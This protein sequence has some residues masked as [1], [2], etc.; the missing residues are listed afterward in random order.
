M[1]L[2][3]GVLILKPAPQYSFQIKKYIAIA[4][5]VLQNVIHH[6]EKVDWL[7][8]LVGEKLVDEP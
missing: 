3:T 8:T 6:E 5:C 1:L 4:A 2:K 7:F